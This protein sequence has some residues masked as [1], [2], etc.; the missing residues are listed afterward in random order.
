MISVN[1]TQ[2]CQIINDKLY[3]KICSK[4]LLDVLMCVISN[5]ICVRR[6][7]RIYYLLSDLFLSMLA[8]GR[9]VIQGEKRVQ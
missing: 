2:I 6:R 7:A 5:A 1:V 9:T 8:E 3:K 4:L